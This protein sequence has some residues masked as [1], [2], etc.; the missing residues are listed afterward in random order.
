MSEEWRNVF[1]RLEEQVSGLQ[2]TIVSTQTGFPVRENLL[3]EALSV[4]PVETP[5]LNRLSRLQGSG[6]AVEWKELTGFTRVSGVFYAEGG[7]PNAITSVY[8]AQSAG[9]KL[10]GRLFGVTGFARAA[11]ANFADQLVMERNNAVIG[12]KQDVEDAIINADGSGDSFEGLIEQ[13]DAGNGSFVNPIGGALAIDDLG[14]ALRECHDRGY[15]VNFMLVNALQAEQINNLILAG[16]THSITVIRSE[17]GMMAGQGR[18]SHL[19]DPITGYAVEIIAHRNL[20]AGTILG[21]PEKLPAPVAGRQGQSGLWWDVLLD[22]TEVEIGATGDT[23]NYFLKTYAT[24]PFP[25]RRG[26]FKLTGVA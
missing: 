18:V 1:Q 6:T 22:Y 12:L 10:M 19:I 3:P 4:F 13:I 23:L 8:A 11:G 17:Q 7:T 16:G 21:I 14:E 20:A 24:M 25:A 5:V 9:Y 2:R 15:Q 26:A